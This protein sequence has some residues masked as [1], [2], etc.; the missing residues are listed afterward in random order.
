[1]LKLKVNDSEYTLKFGYRVMAKTGLLKDVINMR[2][3]FGTDDEENRTDEIIE[4]MPELIELN[5][6]LVLAGLQ[7]YHDDFRVDYDDSNSVKEGLEKAIDFMDDYMDEP[8]AIP[9]MD[10]F[11]EMVNELV[12]NGFLSK[13]SEKLENAMIEQNA[14]VVPMDHKKATN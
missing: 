6:K 8:D 9:V 12:D 5:T 4:R 10:L 14:T 1:M 2:N 11:A 3:F 13:K 7:K